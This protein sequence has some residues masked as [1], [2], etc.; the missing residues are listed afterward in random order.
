M[1]TMDLSGVQ[2]RVSKTNLIGKRGQHMEIG[3]YQKMGRPPN[4]YNQENV[5]VQRQT[6]KCKGIA[7]HNE[8]SN[9]PILVGGWVG[10]KSVHKS[11]MHLHMGKNNII[12]NSKCSN[13]DIKKNIHK[14]EKIVQ[15]DLT[16][17]VILKS[18]FN[19]IHITGVPMSRVELSVSLPSLDAVVENFDKIKYDLAAL[20]FSL[21][22]LGILSRKIAYIKPQIYDQMQALRNETKQQL[23]I[24]SSS[25]MEEPRK[26]QA[27]KC[28][29][30]KMEF[31]LTKASQA[32]EYF[33]A[34][35]G[36]Q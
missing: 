21:Q 14:C 33:V 9:I 15:Y 6:S 1:D 24:K 28:K 31:L 16:E 8:K 34:W 12:D 7:T 30:R 23:Q 27:R 17:Q 5:T 20:D 13:K 35:R 26:K 18:G 3:A 36:N 10:G 11:T 29:T 25:Q 19:S 22:V 32:P 2:I 4:E